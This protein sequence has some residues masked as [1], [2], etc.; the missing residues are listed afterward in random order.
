MYQPIYSLFSQST[1]SESMWGQIV[2]LAYACVQQAYISPNSYA[3]FSLQVYRA[4]TQYRISTTK[5]VCVSS[6]F[7]N[8]H[9]NIK[10]GYYKLHACTNMFNW[11]IINHTQDDCN[12]WPFG[13]CCFVNCIAYGLSKNIQAQLQRLLIVQQQHTERGNSDPL[14]IFE[15]FS[16]L[17]SFKQLRIL[18][19]KFF[20][21]TEASFTYY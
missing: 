16:R 2:L 10:L 6:F 1:A 4:T 11:H 20:L 12:F 18:L 7:L 13:Y 15:R 8:M 9:E 19:I 21:L 17:A 14:Q 5:F 3:P